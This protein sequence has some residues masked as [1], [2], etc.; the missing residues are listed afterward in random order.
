[1]Q[2]AH[3]RSE[4]D[5]VKAQDKI[6]DLTDRSKTLTEESEKAKKQTKKLLAATEKLQIGIGCRGIKKMRNLAK[7]ILGKNYE[8][9]K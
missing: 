3:E 8:P 1:M 5:L 9:K 6:N 7:E 4:K 2:D